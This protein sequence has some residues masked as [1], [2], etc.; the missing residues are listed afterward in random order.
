ME[1]LLR[2]YIDDGRD[3]NGGDKERMTPL[4]W[5]AFHEHPKHVQLLLK[6]GAS[7]DVLDVEGKTPL[8]WSP[9]SM[10]CCKVCV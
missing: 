4:H 1:L 6:A 7:A 3:I 5:A 10:A 2:R 9:T 8:H